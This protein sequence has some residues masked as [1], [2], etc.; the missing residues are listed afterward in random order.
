[1]NR[2]LYTKL[3]LIIFALILSLMAVVGAFLMRGI[4][5]FYV[6]SFYTQM[7]QA[8]SSAELADGLRD[9]A[10]E[11]NPVSQMVAVLRTY[12][13]QLGI[14]AGTRN[15]YILDGE[16]GAVLGGSDE[17]VTVLP[18]TANIF[19]AMTG[20]PGYTS[21]SQAPYMDVALPVEGGSKSFIVYIRDDKAAATALSGEMFSI[22]L[23]AMLIGLVIALALGLLL[24]RAM[25][26]PIQSLTRAARRVA[27]GD[28]SDRLESKAKDEI[29]VLSRT[30]NDMAVQLKSTLDNLNQSERMRREF[31]AN[32][33]H[34]LRTPIT[35]I[36]SYAETLQ[37][38]ENLPAET[39]KEFLAVIVGES[40]RMTNIVQDLLTLSK[41][42]AG[43][44][45]F[46]FTYFPP[47]KALLSVSNALALEAQ[48]HS[49]LFTVDIP[50]Q[51]LPEIRGDR[52]RLEQVLMNLVSNA[53]KYTP[54]GGHVWL[55]ARREGDGVQIS[56]RDNGIGI[57]EADAPHVFERFYRVDKARSRESG[58]TG[59]GLP[60][61]K[62]IVERHGGSI[63][64]TSVL[65][66]GTSVTLYLPIGGPGNA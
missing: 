56:V 43:S 30:F 49:H 38:Q 4:R 54:D 48:R 5:A 50:E 24:A 64:L 29:G 13:G 42:D 57:P 61:A 7:N 1:M 27:G 19:T 46:S 32:V 21:D 53:I 45:D 59:L 34:E 6:S 47:E 3:V 51:G 65:G 20:Q 33:S 9:A 22:I 28:F 52:A 58:G 37:D 63:T 8:F 11:A 16:T 60:I 25:V 10:G 18:A 23:D 12:A 66:A 17:T 44:A 31:V 62:E 41:F 39:Q 26:M 55:S 35:S 2:S 36:R 15:Y 40:D 14:D